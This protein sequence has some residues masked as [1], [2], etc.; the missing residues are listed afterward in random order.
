MAGD[1]TADGQYT[2][3]INVNESTVGAVSIV[4]QATFQG[5]PL[6]S[7]HSPLFISRLFTQADVDLG[8][9]VGA[10]SDQLWTSVLLQYGDTP[11]ARTQLIQSLLKTVGV[12][13]AQVDSSALSL[14]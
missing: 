11:A 7:P 6:M 8:N 9:G 3:T 4:A 13:S 12:S 10:A 5:A 2:C 14:A 1:G